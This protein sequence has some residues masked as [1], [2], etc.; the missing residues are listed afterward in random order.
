MRPD[1]TPNNAVGR[2][3]ADAPGNIPKIQTADWLTA[4]GKLSTIN[5]EM[6]GPRRFRSGFQVQVPVQAPV[7]GPRWLVDGRSDPAPT[8]GQT[9][10]CSGS[11]FTPHRRMPDQEDDK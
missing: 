6:S 1:A 10:E 11:L 4:V 8:G 3:P 5:A 9:G 2:K 7:P